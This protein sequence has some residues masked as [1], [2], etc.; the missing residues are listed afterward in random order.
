MK[1]LVLCAG[2]GTRLGELTRDAPKAMLP[3]CG[4]PL[5]AYNLRYLSRYGFDHVAVNLH[6]RAQMITDFFGDG[7][8]FGV[9]V[10]YSCEEEPLGTAGAI[11]KLEAFFSDVD[12]FL[13]MY[14][15]LL[16]DHDL[17]TMI[18][19]HRARGASAT[20]LLHQRPGSN[21]L[22]QMDNDNR[23]VGFLERPDA[24][25]RNANPYPWVNSGVQVLSRRILGYIPSDRPADLPRDVYIPALGK[26]LLIGVPLRGY[27]CAIDSAAR[28]AEACAA[29]SE[30]RYSVAR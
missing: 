10:H 23:I 14:G 17:S 22:V 2:Y 18:G 16:V 25:E 30:G 27:R 13:V 11:R 1:A 29:A 20:L 8:K 26:E 12:D 15:D 24:E 9:R 5:L 6:Y 4:Q 3:I 19:V 21:S 28:Y 7:R